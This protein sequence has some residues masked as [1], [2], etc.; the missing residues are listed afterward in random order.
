MA[1]NL[2]SCYHLR[3]RVYGENTTDQNTSP[4]SVK[5]AVAVA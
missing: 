5:R 2:S 3:L 1:G 4:A